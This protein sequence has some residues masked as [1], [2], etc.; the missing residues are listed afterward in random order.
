MEQSFTLTSM[1]VLVLVAGIG[2]QVLANI[3]KVPSIVFLLVFG[4]LLGPDGEGWV[5]PE[6]LGVGI[7]VIVALS[8]ALILFEGGLKEE[9]RFSSIKDF[10]KWYQEKFMPKVESNNLMTIP[11]QGTE[12]EYLL[13][14]PSKIMAMRVEPVFSSSVER[15]Y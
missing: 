9:V 13:A 14:R 15:F 6:S 11:I 3:V 4:V 10:Q 7:E 2:A 12:G 5:S 1:M 8:V